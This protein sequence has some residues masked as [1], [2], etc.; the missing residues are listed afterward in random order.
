MLEIPLISFDGNIEL[1]WSSVMSLF[2]VP[3]HSYFEINYLVDRIS[4]TKR[5]GTKSPN[6]MSTT[7]NLI[8]DTQDLSGRS[9]TGPY[10]TDS[11]TS[12]TKTKR[13]TKH[14]PDLVPLARIKKYKTNDKNSP[15]GVVTK[16][17]I[18]WCYVRLKVNQECKDFTSTL[19]LRSLCGRPT[20][21]EESPNTG[22]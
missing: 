7:N 20:I 14:T 21:G 13:S 18:R 6:T 22:P 11:E 19:G 12:G 8:T 5:L 17:V 2:A 10:D 1:S 16:N 15:S 3:T 4:D 9:G